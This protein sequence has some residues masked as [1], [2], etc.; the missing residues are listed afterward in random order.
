MIYNKDLTDNL[1]ELFGEEIKEWS[2]AKIRNTIE[3]SVIEAEKLI[4]DIEHSVLREGVHQVYIKLKN[5]DNQFT[6]N[7]IAE[8][9]SV[10][11]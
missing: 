11:Q 6:E 9:D 10:E 8:L 1:V 7:Y 4:L 5:I 2:K 3:N